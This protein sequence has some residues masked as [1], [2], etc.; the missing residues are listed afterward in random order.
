MF[1]RVCAFTLSMLLFA[2]SNIAQRNPAPQET[3]DVSDAIQHNAVRYWGDVPIPIEQYV[4]SETPRRNTFDRS[5][6]LHENGKTKTQHHLILSGGGANGAFGAGLLNAMSDNDNRPE[7][8]LVTGISTGALLGLFAF[9]GEEY[10]HKLREFYTE[11]SDND[12]YETRNIWQLFSSSSLLNTKKFEQKVRSEV[13]RQLLDKVK[14]EYLRGRTFLV[15]TT[16]LDS[17]RPVVWNM[18]AIALSDS[19]EAES[20]FESVLIASAAIPGIFEPVLIPTIIDGVR[21]DEMHVDGGVV[22]Q[23]FFLPEDWDVE[24][25]TRIEKEALSKLGIDVQEESESAVWIINNARIASTWQPIPLQLTDITGRSISTM[26]KYQGRNN[27]IQIHHQSQLTGSSFHLS[28]IDDQIPGAP[29]NAPFS[30]EYMQYMYCYG[31]ARGSDP[32][33]WT[34]SVP[35]N[36]T[37][38]AAAN[39]SK[40]ETTI[41]EFD[42]EL[43]DR[44]LSLEINKC[45][46]QLGDDA[47]NSA[48]N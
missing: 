13:D 9:L 11:L 45:L 36:K 38:D 21:Y 18:G 14:A 1:R 6:V 7:Y 42:W 17:Q 41:G 24:A 47:P 40:L 33:H 46:N 34:D 27:L 48:S 15:K 2:C 37:L 25:T 19:D 35:Q 28:Y 16:N 3:V 20:L 23:S 39:R 29:D 30:K 26:I 32:S 4:L 22:A 8:R 5:L 10:D 44:G 12:L 31:Y 43:I